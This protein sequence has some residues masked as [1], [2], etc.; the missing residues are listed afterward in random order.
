MTSATKV[1]YVR[2]VEWTCDLCLEAL[3][4]DCQA[5]GM[6][7][8]TEAFTMF[9]AGWRG[10]TCPH[11]GA[12]FLFEILGP[13]CLDGDD[14]ENLESERADPS[15][16]ERDDQPS[17]QKNRWRDLFPDTIDASKGIGYPA[18][19]VGRYGSYPQNDGCEDE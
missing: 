5:E 13:T 12:G 9:P 16:V 1:L 10:R 4:W 19:E 14:H 6:N 2:V 18:R 8:P 11:G 7:P 3:L 17:R 15:R